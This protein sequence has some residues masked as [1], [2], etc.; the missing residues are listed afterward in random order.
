MKHHAVIAC[1]LD[2]SDLKDTCACRSHLKHLLV[3]DDIDLARITDDARICGVDT[4]H[5]GEY[6]ADICLDTR[7]DG[8]GGRIGATSPQRGDLA[9]DGHALEASDDDDPAFIQGLDDPL[10]AH[11][12][13]SGLGVSRIG[14]DAD[15][16][17]RERDGL[18]PKFVHGHGEQRDCDLLTRG[19]QHVHLT[20]GRVRGDLGGKRQ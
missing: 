19:E 13:D 4:V 9:I 11:L 8:N 15:L 7:S 5:V 12:L 1:E 18:M 6:L 16:V 17:A 2:A 10:G 20:L 14:E 3:R